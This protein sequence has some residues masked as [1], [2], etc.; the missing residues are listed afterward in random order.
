MSIRSPVG[1]VGVGAA[2]LNS[3]HVMGLYPSK[4]AETMKHEITTPKFH[5]SCR[6]ANSTIYPQF[7]TYCRVYHGIPFTL[8]KVEW[9]GTGWIPKC[10][11]SDKGLPIV[12]IISHLTKWRFGDHIFHLTNWLSDSHYSHRSCLQKNAHLTLF[13][14]LHIEPTLQKSLHLHRTGPRQPLSTSWG[15]TKITRIPWVPA[16]KP[17]YL[18]YRFPVCRWSNYLDDGDVPQLCEIARK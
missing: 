12:V 9:P 18:W 3:R 15:T 14:R 2:C 16:G 4:C 5:W 10:D 1:D 6:Q 11:T 8:D 7:S 17:T 13:N